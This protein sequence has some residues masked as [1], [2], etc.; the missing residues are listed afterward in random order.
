LFLFIVS[1]GYGCS[2]DD[3]HLTEQEV[4][5][6][7][8]EELQNYLTED[9]IIRLI[10]N[11]ISPSIDDDYLRQII[12]EELKKTFTQEQIQKIID[13]RIGETLLTEEEIR[14]II[15]DEVTKVKT[16]WQI[17]NFS[18]DKTSWKWDEANARYEA[19]GELPELTEFIYEEGANVGYV[20]IGEQGKNEV[21]KILPYVHTY[22]VIN[23]KGEMIGQFTETISFDIQYSGDNKSTVAFYIQASDLSWEEEAYLPNYNFRIVL[24]W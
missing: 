20:F 14:K 19:I 21:Q 4:R 13:E 7:I 10:E 11:S 5:L 18:L 22:S 3:D 2:N 24:I 16:N 9:E 17:I 15:Q 8:R 12:I 1:L 23:D 6:I